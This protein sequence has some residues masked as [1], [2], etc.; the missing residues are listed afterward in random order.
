MDKADRFTATGTG[1]LLKPGED[2]GHTEIMF[3]AQ[4]RID[5]ADAGIQAILVSVLP[6][7]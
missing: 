7:Q 1:I 4:L 5:A 3:Q 6:L 2:A